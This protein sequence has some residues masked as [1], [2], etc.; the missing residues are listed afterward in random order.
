MPDDEPM[1]TRLR[2]LEQ[3]R[4]DAMIAGDLPTLERLFDDDLV[5][6]HSSG[7]IDSKQSYNAGVRQKLWDYHTIERLDEQML[8]R[9][10][11]SVALIF[12]R[13]LMDIDIR[14]VNTK[15]DNNTLAVWARSDDGEW[16][17]VALNS[18][19]RKPHD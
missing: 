16:T 5:Y 4:C 7:V 11:G 15:L 12:N 18:S 9:G 19:P 17:F 8:L 13:T 14:G 3:E 6:V 2:E 1:R 10:G